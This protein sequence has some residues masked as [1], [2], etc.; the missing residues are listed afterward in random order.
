MAAY[1]YYYL[2][3]DFKSDQEYFF[4]CHWLTYL[5]CW[6]SL[7]AKAKPI[8]HRFCFGVGLSNL[9]INTKKLYLNIQQVEKPLYILLLIFVGAN[10]TI[11]SKYYLIYLLIFLVIH[12]IVIVVSG[13]TANM[14]IQKKLHISGFIG[15]ANLGMGGLSLAI[16]LDFHLT[17]PSSFSNL[18]IFILA[19]SLIVNDLISY[20]F[21]EKF[22]VKKLNTG[23]TE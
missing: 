4:T 8:I 23:D 1:L 13:F 5:Y 7:F 10:I 21:L 15:L 2:S 12:L 18:L 11:E 6:D 16:I 20:K 17:N 19:I 22:L 14:L 9:K 3:K